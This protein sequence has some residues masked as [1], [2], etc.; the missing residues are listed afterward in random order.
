MFLLQVLHRS[1]YDAAIAGSNGTAYGNPNVSTDQSA[2]KAAYCQANKAA[3]A[4]T[5]NKSDSA[6]NK[7]PD[8]AAHV[9]SDPVN[10]E[11]V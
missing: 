10:Q 3:D 6:A 5:Y 11:S 9:S 8:A 1:S 2:V 7:G 4:S